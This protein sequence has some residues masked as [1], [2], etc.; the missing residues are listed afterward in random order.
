VDSPK[1]L[2]AKWGLRPKHSWG[3]NFLGDERAQQRIAEALEISPGERVLELG[4]G[5]GHL[6]RALLAAGAQVVAV[7]KD[8]EVAEALEA[9]R[10]SGLSVVQLNAARI[11]FREVAGVP[12][13]AVVGNLPYHLSSSILFA[14]LEQEA[15][16]SRAVFTLQRE[17]VERIAAPPGS[18]TY[19]LLSALLDL[20]F[21]VQ[22]LWTI[23]ASAFY[24]PPKVESAVVR[25]LHRPEPKAPLRDKARWVRLVKA[26]FSHRRKTLLNSLS[27]DAGL[28][29]REELER[30]L[31]AAGIDGSLRAEMLSSEQFAAIEQR[32]GGSP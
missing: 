13:V 20:F 6:S 17:V 11:D 19:G 24:P 31:N 25:L 2:L 12:K 7:E 29:T 1:A 15:S 16:V 26:A 8:R 22:K 9:Q 4:A 28:G 10:L 32:L 23:P 21:E 18:R 30:A 5:L 27:T 14:V 3:Q